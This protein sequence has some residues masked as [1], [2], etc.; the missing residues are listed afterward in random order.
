[1]RK[2]VVMAGLLLGAAFLPGTP[3]Q[4][5]AMVGCQCVRLGGPA[6]CTATVLE[7][8]INNGGVCVAPCTYEAPKAAKK[9]HGKKKKKK[10]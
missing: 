6:L 1:M 3:A 10:M 9:H 5:Q 2:L 4:A 7:C 8:N